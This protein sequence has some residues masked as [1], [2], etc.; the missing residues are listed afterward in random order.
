MTSKPKTTKTPT[1]RFPEFSG[2]WEEK[3]LGEVLKVERGGSPRPI[4][5]YITTHEEGIPWIKI[6]D[7]EE[8]SRYVTSTSEKIIPEGV[9]NSREVFPGDFILSNSM[10][11]GRPYMVKIHGCIHDGWLALRI[12]RKDDINDSFLFDLLQSDTLKRKFL[13]LAAGSAVRNLKS[14]AVQTTRTSF[15][16]ITEQRKIASF[17]TTVDDWI[18]N[19]KKQKEALE[20]Y[21]KGMLQK[22]FSQEI[23]FKDENGKDYPEWEEKR[24]GEISKISTGQ[25]NREDSNITG[26]Y[27]F[28]DRSNEVRRSN[29]FLFDDEAIIIAGEGLSFI[30]KYF[31]GKFDLH[32]RAYAILKS[33]SSINWK[34]LFYFVMFNRLWFNRM[35]VGSTMPSLRMDSFDKLTVRIP[36]SEEQNK[37]TSFLS[38]IDDLINL[39]NQ[40]ITLVEEWKKGLMQGMFV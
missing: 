17:L 28:F 31:H 29:I 22:L 10:S 15:P 12:K 2:E 24:L 7:L 30:P 33:A 34:Y 11:F 8:G 5:A 9:K 40:R 37:I 21:K 16:D 25:S 6:G 13:S 1:L 20:E 4:D 3:R 32:Q 39:S 18:E 27:H 35:A 14:E 36:T 19:L 26:R 38:S 23:R